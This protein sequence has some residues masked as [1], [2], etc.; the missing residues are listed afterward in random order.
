MER[1]GARTRSGRYSPTMQRYQKIGFVLGP[2]LAL[3]ILLGPQPE[4][5][6][7]AAWRTAAVA[8]LMATWWSTE[9]IP[10][11][12]TSLLPV[13]L[14]PLLEVSTVAAA[15]RP[16][17]SPVIFLLLGG[18]MLALTLERWQL[19]RRLA[20]MI[21][22]RTGDRPDAIVF[23]FM[24]A[25]ALLSMWVSNSATTL[26][27]IPIALSVISRIMA[28]RD[29]QSDFAVLL[30]LGLAYAASIGGLGT[31]V[32][33][34][35]NALA[36]GYLAEQYDIHIRFVDWM[37]VGVPVVLVMVP[38][39][40]WIM[41]RWVYPVHLPPNPA[42]ARELAEELEE[43][44]PLSVPERRT[45]TVFGVVAGAWMLQ[46]LLVHLPGLGALNDTTI[47]IAGALAMFL[48][49]SGHVEQGVRAGGA[50]L[51]WPS[52]QKLPWGVMLLFGSG[53]SLAEQVSASGLALWLGESLAALTAWPMIG[54]MFA[55]VGLV[56]FLTELTS[57][58]GLTATILP[59]LGVIAVVGG[60]DPTLLA[61]PAALAASC[62]FMLPVATAPN[63][64][65]FGST[66]IS[67]PQMVRAGFRLNLM[68]ICVVTLGGYWLV[69]VVLG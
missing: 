53:M 62:A 50:L 58:T 63:A 67:I 45:A 34:P 13:V 27:M 55:V 61:V 30:L 46:P 17:A 6:P 44:G 54:L 9:A 64:I 4:T 37:L 49:P 41:T 36:V 18:F 51:D 43:L 1:P 48:V 68:A 69:P 52:T 10:V 8:V 24:I 12:A 56:V 35:P 66:Y 57:N 60:V 39:C 20:L 32:G 42:A 65:V 59:V 14:F 28:G 22:V 26:M 25:A 7:V 11:P 21:L 33:T 19:H 3:L 5:V 16:F 29:Q 40:W 47:A 23:G 2:F 15:T 31:I 38:L